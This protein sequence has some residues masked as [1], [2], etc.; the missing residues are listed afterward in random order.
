M[1]SKYPMVWLLGALIALIAYSRIHG[2]PIPLSQ[3]QTISWDSTAVYRAVLTSHPVERPRTWRYRAGDTYIYL[4]K[5]STLA[6]PERGDT[7]LIMAGPVAQHW[8]LVGKAA[9]ARTPWWVHLRQRLCE[10][11]DELGISERERGT[12]EALTLGYREDLDP[13]V[14]QA[15]QAAGAMHVLAVSGL[16]TGI[17]YGVLLW[18]LTLGGRIRPMYEERKKRLALYL[19]LILLLWGYALLT[20]MTPS[21][22]RSALMITVILLGKILHRNGVNFNSLATAAF[23]I[24]IFRPDDLFSIGFQLSFAAVAAIFAF[25]PWFSHILRV[26]HRPRWLHA[27]LRYV[28]DLIT[29]SLAAQLGTLPL[30]M[31]YFGETSHYFLLTNLLILPLAF[32]LF[33]LAFATL[34]IGWLPGFAWLAIPTGWAT[35]MMNHAVL[36]IERLPGA[37]GR[38]L[39]T[40]PMA[41]LLY[42]AM[43]SGVLALHAGAPTTQSPSAGASSRKAHTS[44]W[45]LLATATI[46]AAFL[47]LYLT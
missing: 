46:L 1:P 36:W 19:T 47:Y 24:L 18:V 43:I 32:V 38:I 17:L 30:T 7:V 16:H 15:F 10:R 22:V 21:V 13:S 44:V 20:G 27:P 40:W 45:C 34:T 9:T 26:P 35:W 42:A 2:G 25:V 5:D 39:V 12:L 14:R 8:K 6:M 23:L 11:Y 37:T 31:H 29:V 4:R 41:A 3:P 33:S 28:R